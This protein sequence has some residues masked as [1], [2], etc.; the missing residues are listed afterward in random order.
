MFFSFIG[1]FGLPMYLVRELNS[2]GSCDNT[3]F[4]VLIAGLLPAV[5]AALIYVIFNIYIVSEITLI[6]SIITA[7]SIVINC[8]IRIIAGYYQSKSQF[9]ISSLLQFSARVALICCT[10]YVFFRT[11][12]ESYKAFAISLVISHSV[13]LVFSAPK[14]L[15]SRLKFKPFSL[16]INTLKEAAPYLIAGCGLQI[17]LQIPLYLIATTEDQTAKAAGIT[18][19]TLVSQGLMILHAN[20]TVFFKN[21]RSGDS[22]DA[23]DYN[24]RLLI[25]NKRV[26][27]IFTCIGIPFILILSSPILSIYNS[28]FVYYTD[29]LILISLSWLA[30]YLKGPITSIFAR[31][32]KVH[33]ETLSYLVVCAI[34]L[35]I[36][37]LTP[38]NINAILITFSL[39][40]ALLSVVEHLLLKILKF[41]QKLN[42]NAMRMGYM[43]HVLCI[44]YVLKKII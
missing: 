13:L 14:A 44:I 15:L 41:K 4:D 9:H 28:N 6:D 22:K 1:C 27:I 12:F 11:G 39:S 3:Y 26:N 36:F 33:F 29:H 30:Y 16:K 31:E 2:Y 23:M 10:T 7:I 5:T 37:I 19:I 17:F 34:Y 42:V 8:Y 21:M 25:D 38:G 35:G 40:I 24:S 43:L 18:I 32:N 20:T